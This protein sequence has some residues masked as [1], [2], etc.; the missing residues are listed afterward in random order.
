MPTSNLPLI[1]VLA[2]V[3]TD[4]TPTMATQV[5][6]SRWLA[7]G[8]PDG[9][10]PIFDINDPHVQELGGWE[11]P[12]HDKKANDVIKFNRM[13]SGDVQVVSGLN[14]RL[15]IDAS[16]GSNKDAKYE[17]IVWEKDWVNFRE[18]TSFK[19]EV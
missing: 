1:A 13:V 19:P 5:T 16:N 18:L 2:I 14:Y 6:I 17:A 12:E 11:V 10:S 9:F 8:V 3:Y 7:T 4:A 15:I